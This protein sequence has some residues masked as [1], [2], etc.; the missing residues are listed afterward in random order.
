MSDRD[1]SGESNP[2]W[3]GGVSE[4]HYRYKKTQMARYPK[5]VKARKMVHEAVQSGKL[6]REPCEV[7][8]SEEDVQAHHEDYSKPLDVRWLCPEHHR[9]VD[10]E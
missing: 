9:E 4:N 3:K 10:A 8:G 5:K 7:C 6:V 1:Q 2:N